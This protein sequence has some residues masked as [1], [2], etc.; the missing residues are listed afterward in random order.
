MSGDDPHPDDGYQ[1]LLADAK[2]R[3]E[4]ASLIAYWIPSDD[5]EGG[6]VG[7]F[8]TRDLHSST[9][10]VAIGQLIGMLRNAGEQ[11]A[12]SH[13]EHADAVRAVLFAAEWDTLKKPMTDEDTR[14]VLR[15][16]APG[17]GPERPAGGGD[18]P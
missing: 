13:G 4:D 18:Q 11:V 5:D 2:T 7:L 8:N 9:L 3:I 1:Q 10:V 6:Y 16:Q 17:H 15:G 12:Q 14:F